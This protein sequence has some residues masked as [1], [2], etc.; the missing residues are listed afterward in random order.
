MKF[1]LSFILSITFLCQG[2]AL[3]KVNPMLCKKEEKVIV[4]SEK[5]TKHSC[6]LVNTDNKKSSENKDCGSELNKGCC[7]TAV[8]AAPLQVHNFYFLK[9]TLIKEVFGYQFS[10]SEYSKIIFHPPAVA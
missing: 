1:L 2:Y 4:G 7:C 5:I 10:F 6:C 3:S 8:L 9:P